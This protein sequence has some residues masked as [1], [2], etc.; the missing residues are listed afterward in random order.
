MENTNGYKREGVQ[1]VCAG[2]FDTSKTI[3]SNVGYGQHKNIS[4][5]G[6]SYYGRLKLEGGERK[7]EKTKNTT[8]EEEDEEEVR[9]ETTEK[10]TEEEED[11]EDEEKRRSHRGG[12][13]RGG[14]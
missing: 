2:R 6:N 12:G 7:A 8:E 10:T 4:K 5:L 14:A 11:D 9:A 1:K 3:T 13:R